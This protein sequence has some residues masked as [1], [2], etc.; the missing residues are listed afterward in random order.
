MVLLSVFLRL[1]DVARGGRSSSISSWCS[2]FHFCCASIRSIGIDA[3]F[4]FMVLRFFVGL[5]VDFAFDNLMK[6]YSYEFSDMNMTSLDLTHSQQFTT[7]KLTIGRSGHDRGGSQDG[8]SHS[9]TC[10]GLPPHHRVQHRGS[11]ATPCKSRTESSRPHGL[12]E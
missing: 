5:A 7:D 12:F 4:E 9:S 10:P 8:T 6:W 3:S 11:V 1:L 2:S